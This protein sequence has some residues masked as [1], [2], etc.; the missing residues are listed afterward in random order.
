ML[1]LVPSL[2]LACTKGGPSAEQLN[3]QANRL[4]TAGD[5]NGALDLY[6]RAEV[7]RPDLPALNY[8]TGNVLNR[9]GDYQRAIDEE[10]QATHTTDADLQADAYY[11]TG[12]N[13]VRLNQL[14][15]AADAY[16]SALRANP[17]D[18]DAKYNLEVVQRQLD[19]QQARQSAL[20]GQQGQQQPSGP[21]NP[22]EQAQPGDQGQGAPGPGQS[23]SAGQSGQP[24]QSGQGQPGSGGPANNASPGQGQSATGGQAGSPVSPVQGG[25]ASGGSGGTSSGAPG[26]YT[27]TAAG[28]DSGV[29]PD[30]KRALGQFDQTNSIDSALQALGILGQQER[31]QA[32]AG[33]TSESNGG[34]Q[35]VGRDW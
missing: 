10:K 9:Q 7:L 31:D 12:D 20:G 1:L 22:G 5:F 23:G 14:R 6:R 13:D 11:S 33:G 8:N 15:E 19:A 35:P 26:G 24:D 18:Q 29:P 32:A 4:Y 17:S 34:H 27:G 3:R 21:S 25:S 30:L 16:K 2:A 28:D